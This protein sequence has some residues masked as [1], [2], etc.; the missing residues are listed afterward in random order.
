MPKLISRFNPKIFN[1]E[2]D[3]A[4]LRKIKVKKSEQIYLYEFNFDVDQIAAIK[5]GYITST[6]SIYL[7]RPLPER[8]LLLKD[9]DRDMAFDVT[10]KFNKKKSSSK[11]KSVIKTSRKAK[12]HQLIKNLQLRSSIRKDVRSK[13]SRSAIL[14]TTV[15]MTAF[16][17]NTIAPKIAMAS[18][19]ASLSM[20]KPKRGFELQSLGQIK[21]SN[22]RRPMLKVSNRFPSKTTTKNETTT[23]IN[24]I[25][26]YGID[27]A[28]IYS[29]RSRIQSS[30]KA[31]SGIAVK[32][33]ARI[34]APAAMIN[35]MLVIDK[36][37]ISTIN[38]KPILADDDRVPI[39]KQIVDPKVNIRKMLLINESLL[40]GKSKFYVKFEMK[41]ES[42]RIGYSAFKTVRHSR[43]VT[44]LSTPRSKPNIEVS[45]YRRFGKNVLEVRQT[46]PI[47]ETIELYRKTINK[48]AVRLTDSS[49]KRI[50]TLNISKADGEKKFIDLVDNSKTH[51]YRAI[52]I[53][54]SG[55]IGINFKSAV[56]KAIPIKGTK[57]RQ[58]INN[59]SI[60]TELTQRGISIKLS[61]FPPGPVAVKVVRKNM[62]L[63][64][65]NYSII[66]DPTPIRIIGST[67][68]TV[69]FLSTDLKEDH[70]YQFAAILIHEDGDE[71]FA[72][73][74]SM[75]Q[76][77]AVKTGVVE[78]SISSAQ[79]FESRSS[80][81]NVTFDLK[82]SIVPNK[83]DIIKKALEEQDLLS[84][85]E[86][87]LKEERE[88]LQKLVTHTITRTDM[89][90]GNT[91]D[92]G[93]FVSGK[94][95]DIRASKL[96]G[97]PS[98]KAGRTYRY[99][100]S[101]Q[102]RSAETIFDKLKVT[103]QDSTTGKKYTYKPSKFKNPFII[104]KGTLKSAGKSSRIT[105]KNSFELGA[106]GSPKYFTINIPQDDPYIK[107]VRAT[108]LDRDTV[109]ISWAVNGDMSQ[110]D[111]FIVQAVKL[112][113]TEFIGVA[114]NISN[115]KTFRFYDELEETN[116][117]IYYRVIMVS[118]NYKRSRIFKS[119]KVEV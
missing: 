108:Q 110:I 59:I 12:P 58:S 75:I 87:V 65:K 84:Q 25:L 76:Y 85:F 53:G 70:I 64:E 61:E 106:V 33:S 1:V 68:D 16:F 92:L 2:D 3:F 101:P 13:R 109:E 103:R 90:N 14:T 7:D 79:V 26:N 39:F 105:A 31:I 19:S 98:L 86:D 56:A 55:E 119:N 114:H 47:A 48:T 100:I 30:Y 24:L 97:A 93:I 15:D 45:P 67:D 63:Y 27:P 82:T 6:M 88:D 62:T 115:I 9:L 21:Q 23:A 102:L 36:I 94:F 40:G 28:S 43:Q 34:K 118:T 17:S 38:K 22:T 4:S 95:D 52:P 73:Q 72:S 8:S 116:Q 11:G 81:F 51:I 83:L 37:R 41:N 112:N 20:L 69:L 49:F 80:N 99:T 44:A 74:V 32:Q 42:G 78:T 107:S 54:P 57:K 111:H 117:E 29:E 91:S 71:D 5:Y 18:R 77:D 46:D 89:M 96:K 35:S 113:E 66:N 10:G 50:G 60:T 104:K